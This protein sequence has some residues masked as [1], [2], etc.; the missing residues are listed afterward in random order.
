MPSWRRH[1]NRRTNELR[2]AAPAVPA[3]M[4]VRRRAQE[5]LDRMPAFEDWSPRPEALALFLEL[6]LF[7]ATTAR[8]LYDWF[9]ADL[10]T[11]IKDPSPSS[12]EILADGTKRYGY[13]PHKGQ[14]SATSRKVKGPYERMASRTP[15]ITPRHQ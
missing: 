8:E 1:V 4:G 15:P 13:G 2:N 7:G 3:G 10:K 9:V 14:T 11:E 5:A 6:K 12:V